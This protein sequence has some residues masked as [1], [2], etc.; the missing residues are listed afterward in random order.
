[1]HPAHVGNHICI[2]KALAGGGATEIKLKPT[3]FA[4]YII[5]NASG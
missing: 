4:A 5:H 2:T 3:D 1:V